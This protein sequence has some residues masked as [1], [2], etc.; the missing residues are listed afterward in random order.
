MMRNVPNSWNIRHLGEVCHFVRG[1]FGGSLKK[2]IFKPNGYAVYEQ[3]HAIYDQFDDVRYYID[4]DKFNELKRFEL[5]SGD[6][7]MS[8][9]G[10][11]GKIAIV[12]ENIK[13]GI[14]NQ[15]LLKLTP[16]KEI[17][18]IFLKLWMESQSFQESL[19]KFSQGAAIQN[20][21]SVAI[22]KNIEMP[23]PPLPQQ[24][25]IVSVL[26]TASALVEKQKALLEK[27]D[28]FLKSKFIEMFGD[29]V[30]NPMGWE[31]VSLDKLADIRT[32]S[33]KPEDITN[34]NYIGLDSIEKGTGKIINVLSADESDLKSNKF[35]FTSNM[36]LYGKLRP[37][38]NK[39]GLPTFDGICSTDIIPIEPKKLLSTRSY[40]AYFFKNDKIVELLS[41]SVSGANLPRVSP[42]FI[43]GL[44]IPKAS[45]DAQCQFEKI[46]TQI[47]NIKEKEQQKLQKLQILYDALMKRAFDGE[48]Q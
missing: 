1:P 32:T 25:K 30:K 17:S 12:P 23:F 20:V 28:L 3:Q 10:T 24:E 36:L 48:I 33:I 43:K 37:Y 42:T 41:N 19:K 5:N 26:D 13:K 18:S 7:I 4:E 21:A 45:F 39:V 9:S 14:I 29:P 11:M 6:L 34:Q 31:V 40:L 22:L 8:C 35:V 44:S 46:F 2:D 16:S 27:Y 38:L 47:E 15:A